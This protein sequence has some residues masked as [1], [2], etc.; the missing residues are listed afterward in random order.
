MRSF[1]QY[2]L[3]KLPIPTYD[4]SDVSTDIHNAQ[5][6]KIKRPFRGEKIVESMR[7]QDIYNGHCTDCVY[8]E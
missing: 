5:G 4:E 7:D 6:E 8:E 2:I 1:K 3:P